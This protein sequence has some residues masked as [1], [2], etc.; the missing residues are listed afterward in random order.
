M[1][2]F[3]VELFDKYFYFAFLNKVNTAVILFVFFGD[4]LFW[5]TSLF[6]DYTTYFFCEEFAEVLMKNGS[7]FE[8][9][10]ISFDFEFFLETFWQLINNFLFFLTKIVSFLIPIITQVFLDFI[11][12]GRT[13]VFL[14]HIIINSIKIISDRLRVSK[15]ILEDRTNWINSIYVYYS[16]N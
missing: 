13:D 7:V 9:D 5:M 1:I 14:F 15:K 10:F 16:K 11:P 12:E 2:T 3:W 4:D 6:L 8:D